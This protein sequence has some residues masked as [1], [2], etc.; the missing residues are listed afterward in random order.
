MD[1]STTSKQ[2]VDLSVVV[3]VYNNAKYIEPTLTSI[4]LQTYP[5]FEVIVVDDGS[6]D[7]SAALIE[8]FCAKDA[9]FTLYRKKNGGV[10]R[11]RNYGIERATGDWIAMCDGDDLWLEDKLAAQIA[12]IKEHEHRYPEPLIA[13]GGAQYFL[14]ARGTK[15]RKF[16]GLGIQ[17]ADEFF[18][19]RNLHGS[20]M[21]PTSTLMFKKE[22]F[23][24]VGGYDP[25]DIAAN[26]LGFLMRLADHGVLLNMSRP[27]GY[28]RVYGSSVTDKKF[29][30]QQINRLRIYENSRRRAHG[31]SE[32]SYDAFLAELKGDPIAFKKLTRDIKVRLLYRQSS[33][34]FLN[35]EYLSSFLLAFRATL[36]SPQFIL[37]KLSRQ[38]GR[39]SGATRAASHK[40]ET[41]T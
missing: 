23:Y 39:R 9:R 24:K 17:T 20:I 26:D 8:R 36:H 12:F 13:V 30:F 15:A 6:T 25:E 14:N 34:A 37:E 38:F 31:E 29:T 41:K 32:L 33:S 4:A 18:R 2:D 5:H 21:L 27:L 10:S 11:A 35:E 16:T 1:I 19:I 40:V 3:T 7:E 22:Y 28:Y